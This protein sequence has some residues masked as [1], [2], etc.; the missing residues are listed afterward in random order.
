MPL[1]PLSPPQPADDTGARAVLLPGGS[2]AGPPRF[3]DMEAR[4]TPGI[5]RQIGMEERRGACACARE[6]AANGLSSG[7][8]RFDNTEVLGEGSFGVVYNGLCKKMRKR[9]A[10]KRVKPVRLGL[11]ACWVWGGRAC[12]TLCYFF[13]RRQFILFIFLFL[14]KRPLR[15]ISVSHDDAVQ[16]RDV[17]AGLLG[18]G[19]T[20]LQQ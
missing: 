1:D 7:Q 11:N 16:C 19:N 8:E 3:S 4:W 20:T 2:D 15:L 14:K 6:M 17:I 5:L 10:V 12:V 9:F 13:S 18:K